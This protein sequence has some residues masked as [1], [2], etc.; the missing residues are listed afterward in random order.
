MS[1]RLSKTLLP[2]GS[3]NLMAKSEVAS[4][5]PDSSDYVDCDHF[6]DQN[7]DFS[8]SDE[9]AASFSGD[10]LFLG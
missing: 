7:S 10:D 6:S 9:A 1:K 3:E 8:G 5:S 2:K 4:F